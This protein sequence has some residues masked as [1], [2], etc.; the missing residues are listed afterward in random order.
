MIPTRVCLGG[1]QFSGF[2]VPG[3][4]AVIICCM[5]WLLMLLLILT[6]VFGP[7]FWVRQIMTRYSQPDDRYPS[8]GG[9]LARH[10]LDKAGLRDVRV[11]ETPGGDHYDPV[12]KA[13][14]LEPDRMHGRSLTAVTV[15]A[16]EVG[17]AVQDGSGYLPLRM[18]TRLVQ[19]TRPLE[20][21]G[22]GILMLT[23]VFAILTRAPL[24][25]GMLIAG[26]LLSLGTAAVVHLVTLPT[27]LDAS[28]SRAL[29]LLNQEGILIPADIPHARR[30]LRAA[31]FTYVA[32]SLM[33]LLSIARW[34]VL[35]R[36]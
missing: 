5:I 29:P 28:F 16:H 25:T 8:T 3:K 4:H 9:E 6:I 2:F 1:A 10:L 30:I 19:M 22:A 34:W 32:A 24:T 11:E 36:R 7:A 35:L 20:R 14:R 12:E 26:G 33:S 31:A 23:P 15:A 18:R 27:E 21:V 17:H 13:V